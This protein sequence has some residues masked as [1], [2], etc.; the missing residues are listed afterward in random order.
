VIGCL[1]TRIQV[2]GEIKVNRFHTLSFSV[3]EVGSEFLLLVGRFQKYIIRSV[4]LTLHQI[5][6]I[7]LLFGLL[8]HNE[9]RILPVFKRTLERY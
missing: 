5:R 8:N 9:N 2:V 6:R 1:R 3:L 4:F 7:R